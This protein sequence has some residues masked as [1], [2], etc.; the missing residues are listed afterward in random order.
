ML[1]ALNLGACKKAN[2]VETEPKVEAELLE[3]YGVKYNKDSIL[4]LMSIGT[5][6]P[7]DSIYFDQSV[8]MFKVTNWYIEFKP[9]N[10]LTLSKR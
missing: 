3:I 2:D 9:E 1:L 8:Q 7:V 6:F 4:N 5:G 10:Y